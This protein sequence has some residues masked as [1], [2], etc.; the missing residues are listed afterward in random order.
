[1]REV[2]TMADGTTDLGN[3]WV[4]NVVCSNIVRIWT[5][6]QQQQEQSQKRSRLPQQTES[7]R[8]TSE[9]E[10]APTSHSR[11]CAH[12]DAQNERLKRCSFPPCTY[13]H[14]STQ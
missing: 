12:K 8:A 5:V 2:V 4:Q 13:L 6:E 11:V 10:V 14:T 1:M 7:T 9:T 3:T